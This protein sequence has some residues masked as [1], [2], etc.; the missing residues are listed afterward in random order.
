MHGA[1]GLLLLPQPVPRAASTELCSCRVDLQNAT[2][3]LLTLAADKC[4]RHLRQA[5]GAARCAAAGPPGGGTS[6]TRRQS[7]GQR[8]RQAQ[9]QRWRG[10]KAE[11]QWRRGWGPRVEGIRCRGG[12]G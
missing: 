8:Q 11:R 7:Q 12:R 2:G 4:G 10:R 3:W 1:F 5:P 9:Q 6:P